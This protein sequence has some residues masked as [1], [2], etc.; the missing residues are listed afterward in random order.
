MNSIEPIFSK[1]EIIEIFDN[2]FSEDE[3]NIEEAL[4]R[5]SDFYNF[6]MIKPLINLLKKKSDNPIIKESTLELLK[7]L[8]GEYLLDE[9]IPLLSSDDASVRNRTVDL[10]S[11]VNRNWITNIFNLLSNKNKD[12]RKLALDILYESNLPELFT[13]LRIGLNDS[14]INNRIAAVEYLGKRKDKTSVDDIVA[15]FNKETNMMLQCSCIDALF[16]IGEESVWDKIKEKFIPID[17][18]NPVLVFSF[19]NLF[20]A[21]ASKEDYFILQELFNAY[22]KIAV[23]E[24]IEASHNYFERNK[25]SSIDNKL[26]EILLSLIEK[27]INSIYK[28][29]ILLFINR[30]NPDKSIELSYKYLDYEDK[31]LKIAAIEIIGLQGNRNDIIKLNKIDITEDKD[32]LEDHINRAIVNLKERM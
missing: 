32:F 11:T 16:S 25:I 22:N 7:I 27:N 14:C 10:I 17:K 31:H 28:Y 26:L 21:I 9:L 30:Y 29:E 18:I 6:F 20:G 2:L 13:G 19:I 8:G 23:R 5:L 24:L 4:D 12:V 15:I 1:E 3:D